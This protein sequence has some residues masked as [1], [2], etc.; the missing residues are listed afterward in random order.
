[1]ASLQLRKPSFDMQR[2]RRFASLFAGRS[3]V[4]GAI[5]GEA[6][7]ETVSL[8]HYRQHLQK[9]TSL[10]IYP[11]R[12]D[13]LVRWGAVDIDNRDPGVA[14]AVMQSLC[15][16]GFNVG[17][18]LERSKSK[19]YHVIVLLSDWAPGID[20]RRIAKAAIHDAGLPPTT[21][22]FPKQDRLTAETPW[23]NY[24]NLPYFGADD[25]EGRRM[26]LDAMSLTPIS[27]TEWLIDVKLFPV[28]A[29]SLVTDE[30]PREAKTLR[31]PG[32]SGA[33]I[34]DMLAGIH[35]QGTRRPT[36]ISLAGYLRYRGVSADVAV[37]LLLPWAREQFVPVLPDYE[38]E[39]HVRG[40]YLRYGQ[41]IGRRPAP[42]DPESVLR[43]VDVPGDVKSALEAVWE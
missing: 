25:P 21:E 29:L 40:I 27:L 9:G 34:T 12:A 30:L 39:R 4:W 26:I 13:G 37:A 15:A 10:G 2:V 8:N 3:D 38:I 5:H 6:V 36:L 17:V 18:Y 32:R 19:G 11:L 41:G 22:V 35:G 24:L 31:P 23:G 7:K 1:M 42:V 16:F 43:M 28:D 20:I 33:E 14:L